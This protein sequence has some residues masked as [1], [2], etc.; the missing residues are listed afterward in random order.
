MSI[1]NASRL[2]VEKKLR[3]SPNTDKGLTRAKSTSFEVSDAV[4]A[5]DNDLRL[6]T[7]I[8]SA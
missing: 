2:K 1:V 7:N 4:A 8:E 3:I 6:M 5:I